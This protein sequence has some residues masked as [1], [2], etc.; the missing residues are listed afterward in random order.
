MTC[1]TRA[2]RAV[3][4]VERRGRV[5]VMAR[6]GRAIAR[7]SRYDAASRTLATDRPD[8]SVMFA[9]DVDPPKAT[10]TAAAETDAAAAVVEA[11]VAA[12]AGPSAA[13]APANAANAA[14]ASEDDSTKLSK[15][16]KAELVA[17]CEE[18]GL[19]A[20]GTVQALRGRLAPALRAKA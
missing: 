18:L 16:K 19:D 13:T 12:T 15:M 4:G 3:T 20:T 10:V 8:G 7:A 1:A 11:P 9:F 6:G 2:A 5:N 17:L 14:S